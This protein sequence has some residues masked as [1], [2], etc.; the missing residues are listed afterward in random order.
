MVNVQIRLPAAKEYFPDITGVDDSDTGL[1][2]DKRSGGRR[3]DPLAGN[4]GLP[5]SAF[6]V[7]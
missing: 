4:S 5:A 6:R 2:L 1:G 3:S 7:C